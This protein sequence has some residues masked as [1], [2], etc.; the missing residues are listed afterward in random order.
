MITDIMQKES[1]EAHGLIDFG[2]DSSEYWDNVFDLADDL[3]KVL[4]DKENE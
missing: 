2:D 4:S 3:L 1:D